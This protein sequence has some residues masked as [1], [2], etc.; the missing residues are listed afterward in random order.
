MRERDVSLPEYV[1]RSIP[2]DGLDGCLHCVLLF[3]IQMHYLSSIDDNE[4]DEDDDDKDKNHC[5]ITL[6]QSPCVY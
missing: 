4:D 5:I 2:Q 1:S 3:P 6:M